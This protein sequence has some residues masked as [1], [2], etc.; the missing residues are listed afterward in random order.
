MHEMQ[1]AV[2]ILL[3]LD[4]YCA[5][6][7]STGVFSDQTS[8]M[9]EIWH[10]GLRSFSTFSLFFFVIEISAN[11]LAF[12]VNIVGHFGYL[13]DVMVVAWQVYLETEGAPKAYKLMNL[14]RLWRVL[15]LFFSMLDIE[16]AAH[17]ETKEVLS[18][19][20]KELDDAKE[21]LRLVEDDIE[22]EKEARGAVEDMLQ[23]YKEE[24]DTLNEA[25]KI[26]AMDIAEVAEAEDDFFSSDEDDDDV[27]ADKF[28]DESSSATGAAV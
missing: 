26:A 8:I 3:L 4:T 25:L 13:V 9:F 17:D 24:V 10:R 18:S 16:R 19:T 21:K 1:A 6:Y 15:R 11:I 28:G 23:N 14:F 7:I 2:C 12:N 5:F 27:T 20:M 22:R